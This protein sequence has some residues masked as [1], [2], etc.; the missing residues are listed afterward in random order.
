ML[1]FLEADWVSCVQKSKVE[2]THAEIIIQESLLW[3][4]IVGYSGSVNRGSRRRIV[5]A[6]LAAAS[7]ESLKDYP[8]IWDKETEAPKRERDDK[9]AGGVDVETG[10]IAGYESDQDMQDTPDDNGEVADNESLG[11]LHSTVEQLG[12]RQAIELRHRLIALV[13]QDM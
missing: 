8:E 5:K 13:C 4:Y 11:E 1:D 2:E 9:Q 12:G 10:D 6:I 3:H 7:V